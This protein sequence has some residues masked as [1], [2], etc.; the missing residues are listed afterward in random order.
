MPSVEL[1]SR[2]RNVGQRNVGMTS[3][4][5]THPGHLLE[6]LQC[7]ATGRTGRYIQA[8]S[9][10]NDTSATGGLKLTTWGWALVADGR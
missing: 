6:L 7:L 9:K 1:G 10:Y 4:E 8:Q 3:Q 2:Q 5:F